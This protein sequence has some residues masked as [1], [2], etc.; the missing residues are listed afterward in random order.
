[1]MGKWELRLHTSRVLFS[2]T[3]ICTLIHHLMLTDT[4]TVTTSIRVNAKFIVVNGA[5]LDD[6]RGTEWASCRA[7]TEQLIN[8]IFTIY[9]YIKQEGFL[10]C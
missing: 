10:L 3:A 5:H 4:H 6:I 7:F 1:M 9:H 2:V 8:Q